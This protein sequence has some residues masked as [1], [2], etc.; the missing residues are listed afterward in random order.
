MITGSV[1][2]SSCQFFMMLLSDC[3]SGPMDINGLQIK[4]VG[5]ERM[6]CVQ[7]A[8]EHMASLL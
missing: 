6:S 5:Q 3:G 4:Q 8:W 1:P 7:N 2:H